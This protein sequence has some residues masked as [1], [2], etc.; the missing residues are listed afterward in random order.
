MTHTHSNAIKFPGPIQ[1]R[2]ERS[3][4]HFL[5]PPAGGAV[6]SFSEPPGEPALVGPD[7]LSWRMFKS[8]L[9][10]FIG[11]VTAVVLQ[12]AE[13]R[14]RAGV[15]DHTSF[16]KNPLQRLQRT[17]L[18]AMMSVYGPRSQAEALIARVNRLHA[19][20][21][22]VSADGH[23]YNALDP[24]LLNWV[25]LTAGYGFTAAYHAF[26]RPITQPEL[27]A[28]FDEGRASSALYGVT[29][30]P[31]TPAESD[32]LFERMAPKLE[33]SPI[34]LEFLDIMRSVPALPR[35]ARPLQRLLVKAGIDILPP[36]VR[37]RLQ[38]GPEWS[39]KRWERWV[40]TRAVRMTDRLLLTSSPA[41][42]ACR[43]LG[44]PD[45]YLYRTTVPA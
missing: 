27:D 25:Q 19:T 32:A 34:V 35:V 20:V 38:L 22:G 28:L 16:R 31:Q 29:G 17:G 33:A 30:A 44:L 5:T 36:W 45:D 40:V 11:G 37:E 7:S 26:Q 43:R 1:R 13:P 21:S 42:Q 15:W 9:V 10:M 6:V 39:L 41:V 12:L 18:A 3:A 23:A 2:L 4:Q 14:V 8:P 24:E